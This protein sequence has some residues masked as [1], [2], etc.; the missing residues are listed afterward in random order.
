MIGLHLLYKVWK[1]NRP[2]VLIKI[3]PSWLLQEEFKLYN[4]LKDFISKYNQFPKK[5]EI[6]PID[7]QDEPLGWYL[8]SI[9]KRQLQLLINKLKL[10]PISEE[11]IED[12]IAE[13]IKDIQEVEL[14][15]KYD[16]ITDFNSFTKTVIDDIR[17]ARVG[18]LNG[19]PTGYATI[20]SLTG[21]LTPSDLFVIVGRLKQGKTIYM[22][23]MLR[24][25]SKDY[26]CMFI[27]MEMSPKAIAQRLL[28]L[29]TKIT[30]IIN[31]ERI[32]SSF[33]DKYFSKINWNIVMLDSSAIQDVT[34]IRY[35]INF[36]QPAVVFIDGAYLLPF[37]TVSYRSEWERAKNTI[38]EL[39]HIAMGTAKPIV[40]SYQLNRQ[41]L[42]VKEVETEHIALS[43]AIGQSASVVLA[44]LPN[45]VDTER[46]LKILA[47]REG[48][49]GVAVR[50]SFDW[51]NGNFEEIT[52][53][54]KV[55]SYD[56]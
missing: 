20:D 24:K 16:V 7:F 23:N 14:F 21:G 54:V 18:G 44:V 19:Y 26:L 53:N 8:E 30:N 29:E 12:I 11:N 47:N 22:L 1:D 17:F 31:H 2:D 37:K 13:F 36:Y 52:D 6:P 46:E 10:S 5:I 48:E 25:L 3:Q 55:I 51:I 4:K 38:E 43:D 32:P 49:S 39:K 42:K 40:C 34:D 27:S 56:T 15:V 45:D 9:K 33:V 28:F 35:L 50:V 41:S